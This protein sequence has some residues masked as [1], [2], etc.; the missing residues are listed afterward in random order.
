VAGCTNFLADNYNFNACVD[1]SSCYIHGCLNE[2]AANYNPD[3]TEDNDSCVFFSVFAGVY[4]ENFIYTYFS[5]SIEILVNWDDD[6]LYFQGETFIDIDM[7][8]T[9]DLKFKIGG[10]NQDST[11]IPYPLEL[12]NCVLTPLN[13]FEIAFDIELFYISMAQSIDI[14]IV[15]QLS[16]ND[17]LDF[18]NNWYSDS[19]G[20]IRMFYENYHITMPFGSWYDAS[21]INYISVRKNDKYG[22]IEV[23][24]SDGL[25]PKIIAYAFQY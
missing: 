15:R 13:G 19:D 7:D 6:N 4:D 8:G 11:H 21:G 16:F 17:G 3:A 12:N 5:N 18:H 10:Y 2:D 24:M 23:D 22:W 9:E 1:D 20:W 25:F 14:D